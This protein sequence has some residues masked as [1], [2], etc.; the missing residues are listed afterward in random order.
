MK[1]KLI[2]APVD[3]STG[4][5]A[6]LE[7]AARLAMKH[8]ATLHVLHVIDSAALTMLAE[9]RREPFDSAAEHSFEH[10]RK[11][12]DE[13]LGHSTLPTGYEVTLVIGAPVHEILEHVKS[14]GADLLVAGV[15]GSGDH[16][17]G[18]GSVAG[19]LARK[20]VVDVLLVR[21]GHPQAFAKIVAALD[22]SEHSARVAAAAFELAG[23]DGT[24]SEVDLLHVWTDPGSML[25]VMGPFGESGVSLEGGSVPPREELLQS[26]GA[27]LHGH[28]LDAPGGVRVNEVAVEHSKAGEGI[29]EH[30]RAAGAE[31]IVIG[32]L[33]RTNLRYLLLG[34][35]AE[36]LL[37][38]VACSVMVVKPAAE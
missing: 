32:A 9:G 23:A 2:L 13:W 28:A 7:H 27:R 12:L 4:S 3:F 34:S 24:A 21:A 22:F 1:P 26:V 33:G 5:R 6:A 30:A 29:A 14:L 8:G 17:D 20:C 15:A 25:P 38:R 36:R 18:A 31:V 11:A 35:T 19:K 16:A 37:S 10:A